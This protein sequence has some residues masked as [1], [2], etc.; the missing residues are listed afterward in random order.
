MDQLKL[1][2]SP[3]ESQTHLIARDRQGTTLLR[4]ALPPSPWH[5][6]ALPRLLE[7]LGSFVPL[8]AALVVA[9][10]APA[11]ATRLYPGWLTDMGGENYEFQIIGGGPRER[12]EWWTHSRHLASG[13]SIGR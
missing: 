5:A 3:S 8:H 9:A 6:C 12:H 13:S 2:I 7:G 11:L 4:A 10:K 1:M